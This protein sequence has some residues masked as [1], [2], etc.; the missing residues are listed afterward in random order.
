[1][2]AAATLVLLVA[3]AGVLLRPRDLHEAVYAVA[4][5]GVMVVLGLEPLG[6]AW[7]VISGARMVLAFLAGVLLLAALA[8]SAGLFELAAERA[9]RLAGRDAARLYWA[10]VLIAFCGTVLL[11]LDAVAVALTPVVLIMAVRVGA[12]A[13]PLLFACISTANAASLALP[14]SN[15][16]NLI[17]TDRLGLS[18]GTYSATMLPVAVAATVAVALVLRLRFRRELGLRLHR[19]SGTAPRAEPRFATAVALLALLTLA[20]FVLLPHDLGY[21]ALAAGGIGAAAALVTR[22]WSPRQAVAAAGVPVLAFAAAIFILV[23]AVEQHGWRGFI[24]RHAPDSLAGTAVAAAAL[25]NLVNNLPAT[26]VGLP[27]ATDAEHAYALLIGVNVGPN[28][29]I[30]GSLATLLWLTLARERDEDVSAVR[31][32]SIGVLTAPAGIAAALLALWCLT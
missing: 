2:D 21:V 5:A 14:V 1:L 18:F 6:D 4:G 20:G 3:L 11:S 16:T 8:D 31:Y 13:E 29:A 19:P 10:V 12:P 26:L 30:T 15:P 23:D 7:D 32:L 24:E 22:R 25:A 27:L 28:L 9:L 17:V